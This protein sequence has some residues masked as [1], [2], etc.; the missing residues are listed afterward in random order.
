MFGNCAWA[1]IAPAAGGAIAC[2]GSAFAGA[3][4]LATLC[5]VVPRLRDCASVNG[6]AHTAR[7]ESRISALQSRCALMECFFCFFIWM[8]SYGML[9]SEIQPKAVVLALAMDVGSVLLAE[10]G[11]TMSRHFFTIL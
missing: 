9:G 3:F 7:S 11:G 1:E 5:L 2:A 6:I 10:R 8:L 4:R